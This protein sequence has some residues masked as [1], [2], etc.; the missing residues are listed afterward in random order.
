M[1]FDFII[2]LNMLISGE[3]NHLYNTIKEYYD[4]VVEKK[5]MPCSPTLFNAGN[6]L[7]QLAA[8]FVIPIEDNIES[9]MKCSTNSAMIFKTG[10]GIGTNYSKL[11]PRGSMVA[12]TSGVASGPISFMRIMDVL[13]DVIKQGGKRRGANMGVLNI[14]HPDI[15]EFIT[16]KSNEFFLENFNLSTMITKNFW[17]AYNKKEKYELVNPKN[18]KVS[19]ELDANFMLETISRL[20]WASGDPGVLFLDNINERNIMKEYRGL[21]NATNPCGEEPLY[22]YESC[23][24]GSLNL[25]AFL[26]PKEGNKTNKKTTEFDFDWEEYKRTIKIATKFM[27]NVIDVNRYPIKEIEFNSKQTRKVGLGFMGLADVL[28]ALKIPYNSEEGFAFMRKATEY[29]TYYSME[30]STELS[31]LKGVFPQ[32]QH[33]GYAKG[34]M[35]IEGF[36]RPN[37]WNLDW[38][39]LFK[40]IRERGMR[41]AET[42]TIAPTGSIS[43][44]A[45]VSSGLEP[46]FALSYEKRV[47]IGTF[48][49]TDQELKRQLIEAELYNDAT[50][51]KIAESGGSLQDTDLPDSFKKIFVTAYDI[52]WWDHVR[53][54]AEVTKWICAAVSKTINMPNKVT[55]EDVL[56]SYLFAYKMGC[57]GVTVYRDGSK[58]VQVLITKAHASGKHLTLVKNETL[59]IMKS[60]QIEP[61]SEIKEFL[62]EDYKLGVF[63]G[64]E[65]NIQQKKK[66]FSNPNPNPSLMTIQ[67]PERDEMLDQSATAR[68]LMKHQKEVCPECSSLRLIRESGC[69]RCID[70]GWSECV[71]A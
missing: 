9:I 50:L 64:K 51:K 43:M 11:R 36:Y 71:V 67:K 5:F 34:E 63:E 12:T 55:P 18:K 37:L 44:I 45:D 53:A 6:K 31:V 24:L 46:Q 33:S 66:E 15:E 68:G 7:G 69:V 22:P 13:T 57:K 28:Y 56:K 61:P 70:C 29:L 26:K 16:V 60:F 65:G 35:P 32:Y 1:K 42:T 62:K 21:I 40:K 4:M 58:T 38:Q 17:E 39:S 41:N 23:N 3:F 14:D 47:P 8:C 59:E 52:P 49:Y 20:A 27:D 10:G 30:S 19:G 25:Y 54:Q 2:I 48:Y